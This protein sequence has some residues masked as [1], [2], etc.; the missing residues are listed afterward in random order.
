MENIYYILK[1]Y[2]II[3]YIF[4]YLFGVTVPDENK[5]KM[6]ILEFFYENI[7]NLKLIPLYKNYWKSLNFFHLDYSSL[8]LIC[9]LINNYSIENLSNKKELI[10]EPWF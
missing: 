2:L 9:K 3:A 5:E 7:K 6:S 8:K 1:K 10:I 4:A